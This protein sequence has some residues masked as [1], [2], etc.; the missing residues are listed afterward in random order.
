MIV[1]F[2]VSNFR[3]FSSEETIS[4]VAS[5]R[6]A[7]QHD[8]HTVPIPDSN[9]R[10][11][12]AAVIYG[13]NG[14]GKSN[15]FKALAYTESI[16]REPRPRNN[17]TRREMF[18]LGGGQDKPTSIDLQFI[19]KNK[20]YRF[21][22]KADD[23]RITEE[24]L[25]QVIGGQERTIYERTT[26][27]RGKVTIDAPGLQ[28]GGEKLTALATVGAPQN[29]SFLATI[30]ANID[31]PDLSEEIRAVLDWLQGGLLLVAPDTPLGSLGRV[32]E[33]SPDLKRFADDFLKSSSTG[34]DQLQV[35][36]RKIDQEELRRD[37]P[38]HVVREVLDGSPQPTEGL[39]RRGDGG[40]ELLIEKGQYYL[41]SV[42]AAHAT[43]DGSQIPLELT[44]E[45]DGTRRLLNLIPALH[46][47][48]KRDATYFIDEI[49]RSMHPILV[50]NFLDFFLKSSS[51]PRQLIVTTHESNLLDLDLL[52]R[53]EIWF[54]EKDQSGATR[55]YSLIDFPIRADSEIKD[56]YL[57]GRFGAIPFLGNLDR[58]REAEPQPK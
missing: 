42:L 10:A 57:Q 12:R 11:I 14:A 54:A 40:V 28:E 55:L 6:L 13:A 2:S 22:F 33:A 30:R 31:S 15:L 23:E 25:L 5:N 48:Q 41:L 4:F 29:Q 19:A 1:S 53:D 27:E 50:R 47:L 43:R 34:V 38:D 17:G 8:D 21:G 46:D 32:L 16:A 52:R 39:F 56:H 24:W 18:R 36:K 37:M 9:E 35:I 26:D 58:L 45:S 49:D 7:G 51:G 20:L 44:L 3:S